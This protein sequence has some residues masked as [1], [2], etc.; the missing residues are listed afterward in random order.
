MG[1]TTALLLCAKLSRF[2]RSAD[3]RSRVYVP[4]I[5][6]PTKRADERD[7]EAGRAS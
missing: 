5:D 1:M 4:T 3:Q 2:S 7:A 6:A